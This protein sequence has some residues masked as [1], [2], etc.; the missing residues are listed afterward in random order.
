M[1]HTSFGGSRNS[2]RGL[3]TVKMYP[4]WSENLRH[5]TSSDGALVDHLLNISQT[6][7]IF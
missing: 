1:K 5:K 6:L 4:I 7:P 3:S 2:K